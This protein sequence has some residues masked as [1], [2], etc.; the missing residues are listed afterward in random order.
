MQGEFGRV[1]LLHMDRSLVPHAHRACHVLFKAGGSDSAF[2]VKD[3]ICRLTNETAVVV[4]AWEQHSY[5]HPVDG[6]ATQILALYIE[7]TWLASIDRQLIVSGSAE[8]F[9]QPNVRLVP[10]VAD[11]VAELVFILNSPATDDQYA[12]ECL[13][14]DLMVLVF[15]A[16]SNRT[17]LLSNQRLARETDFR[18][19][20]AINWLRPRIHQPLDLASMAK[21]S[22]LSRS[23][24]FARFR[25]TTGLTPSMFLNTLR[26]EAA[27]PLL[28][29]NRQLL[30]EVGQQLGFT[31]QGNFS[32]FFREH[33]GVSPTEYRQVTQRLM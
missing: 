7:P 15:D 28:M 32:R 24:L 14:F 31:A 17:T 5:T 18:V 20:R 27:H 21:A 4:N 22:G 16:F 29:D 1:A 6:D 33:Q 10:G 25:Q 26:M 8:F 9:R 3:Q 11:K 23:H 13:V 30:I 2:K 12:I 19:R